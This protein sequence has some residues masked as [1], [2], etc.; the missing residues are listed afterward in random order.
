V[1]FTFAPTNFDP[2]VHRAS[3]STESILMLDCGTSTFD[4]ST[5]T[6]GNWCDQ[7]QPVPVIEQQPDGPEIVIL[8]ITTLTVA[9]GSTLRLIG[10]RPVVFAVF[11][12]A[13]IAGTLDAN[14]SGTTP[15]AGGNWSCGA[16]QGADGS[17]RTELF[18]GASGGGGGG[19]GT[20]GGKSGT[21]DTDATQAA[22]A[23][24][25][26]PRGN[27]SISPLLG[28]CAGGQAG[29]CAVAGGAGG[30][31]IQISA[32]RRLTITGAVFANGGTGATPCDAE[33]EGGG[34]GGGSGG[35]I[36]LEGKSVITSGATLE[37][38]GGDGGSNG[39]FAGIYSCGAHAGGSGARSASEAARDGVDCQ[40][41]SPGGGG[42]YGRVQILER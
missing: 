6:F 31:A 34:T 1:E 28:G 4:S 23:D 26:V 3:V 39:A 22:G 21:A 17:G 42:G 24:G 12:D 32:A 10:A 30:G 33:Q 8:P 13:L 20:A 25:G 19:Y 14:A 35:A 2:A 5:L 9:T 15:G 41:G 11:G 38:N 40:G 27:D 7:V 29:G 36:L 18:G 16:S 37:V